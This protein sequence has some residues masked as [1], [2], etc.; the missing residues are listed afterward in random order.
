MM[1]IKLDGAFYQQ[2]WPHFWQTVKRQRMLPGLFWLLEHDPNASEQVES[3][4]NSPVEADENNLRIRTILLIW[5]G[6]KEKLSS[7][8]SG[9]E[10]LR[11][12]RQVLSFWHQQWSPEAIE[13]LL[14]PVLIHHLEQYAGT[15]PIKHL[16]DLY[17]SMIHLG[18]RRQAEASEDAVKAHFAHRSS[19]QN[20]T[21]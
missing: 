8:L 11:I 19:I 7:W 5:S 2:L 16:H 18:M 3:W 4:L 21:G 6:D 13:A 17:N 9:L 20:P 12:I 14:T 15:Q 1:M 10:D